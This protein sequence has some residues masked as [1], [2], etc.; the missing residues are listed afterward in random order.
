[1]KLIINETL[2]KRNKRIGNILSILGIAILASGLILNLR[3][4][5]TR[6]TISFGALIVGFIIAQV[7]TYYVN[8]FGRTPRF[9]EIIS[10]NLSKLN[11]KYSFYVYRSPV[12]LLITGPYGLWIPIPIAASGELYYDKKWKQ[13]G[14]GFLLKFFGQENIGRPHI[15]VEANEKMIREFLEKHFSESEMPT[16]K[17]ILVSLHPKATIGDVES[18]PTPIVEYDGLRR[19]IRKVDR[20]AEEELT[21]EM[22]DKLN[23]LLSE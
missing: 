18:A 13:R 15:D 14:G 4:T 16:V 19:Y 11:N 10:D 22:L 23:K 7:S 2:I 21:Q 12:P 9:D 20:K 5:P 8:K 17:S 1:M 3:P 6:T